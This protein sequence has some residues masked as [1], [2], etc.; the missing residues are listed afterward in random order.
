[1]SLD[2]LNSTHPVVQDVRTVVQA[3][4]AFDAIA[5]SK[6]ESVIAMLET[7]ATPD[8]WRNGIR[9]LCNSGQLC[10][11]RSGRYRRFDELL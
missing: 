1:M 10:D 5:Y 2:A 4:Q 6:G 9:A 7:F 11:P 8:V 3:N